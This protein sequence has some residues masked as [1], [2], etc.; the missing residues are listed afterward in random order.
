M[1]FGATLTTWIIQWNYVPCLCVMQ[2]V[3]YD[4]TL[5]SF[6][7]LSFINYCN[8]HENKAYVFYAVYDLIGLNKILIQH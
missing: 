7:K 6:F 8:F 5:V 4:A 2:K 1:I 3:K